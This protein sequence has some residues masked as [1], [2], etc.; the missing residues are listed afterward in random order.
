LLVEVTQ[1]EPLGIRN[2]SDDR[3]LKMEGKMKELAA[4]SNNSLRAIGSCLVL[5]CMLIL[6]MLGSAKALG[7]LVCVQAESKVAHDCAHCNPSN[8]VRTPNSS[9][10]KAVP[11]VAK[12]TFATTVRASE[13]QA[14]GVAETCC[15]REPTNKTGR[16]ES[17]STEGVQISEGKSDCQCEMAPANSQPDTDGQMTVGFTFELIVEEFQDA[18]RETVLS[19][20]S[21]GPYWRSNRGPPDAVYRL[22]PPDRAPPSI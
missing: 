10:Q 4:K 15:H 6:P 8:S 9:E 2:P 13:T 20:A 21:N 3:K 14:G 16:P 22:G 5:F 17:D 11:M 18:E 19:E 1:L 12:A 7:P